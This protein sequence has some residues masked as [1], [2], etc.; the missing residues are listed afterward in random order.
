MGFGA[1]GFPPAM[2]QP[3]PT[4][5][6]WSDRSSPVVPGPP[7]LVYFTAG[8]L[9]G[10]AAM[11][12]LFFALGGHFG[13]LSSGPPQQATAGCPAGT[14][15]SIGSGSDTGPAVTSDSVSVHSYAWAA[16]ATDSVVT[17]PISIVAGSTVLIFVGWVGDSIGGPA[18]VAVCDSSDD[19]FGLQATTSAYTSNHS[20]AMFVAFDVEGGSAVSFAANFTDTAAPAGGVVSVVD[21]T[22][23]A[24]VSQPD[25]TVVNN[26]GDNGTAT[27][28]LSPAMPSLLVFTVTGQGN[29]GP[30]SPFG[31]ETLLDTNGYFDAG[32]WTDGES[33][34][35][36]VGAVPAGPIA[37]GANLAAGPYV[38]NAIAV[39]ID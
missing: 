33:V 11:L 32:P 38:W 34:G 17:H 36:M 31:S 21:L 27:V 14:D 13:G 26:E 2:G 6:Q 30:Y 29:A 10:V 24:G 39:L 19:G 1:F 12:V 16:G 15:A 28:E 37:C 8:L 18:Q 22:G 4:F 20:Q 25:L 3:P 9:I 5:P 7:S 35:T 23:S